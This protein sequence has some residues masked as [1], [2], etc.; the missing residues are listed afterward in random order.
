MNTPTIE[1]SVVLTGSV[2]Y[3]NNAT[4]QSKAGIM[5]ATTKT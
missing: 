4:A 5:C 3:S 1:N 2:A